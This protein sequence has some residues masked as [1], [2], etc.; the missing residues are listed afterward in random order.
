MNINSFM[1][2]RLMAVA[3]MVNNSESVA[4]IGTDHGYVPVHLVLNN[5]TK[6]AL[7]MDINEGPLARADENI[8]RFQLSEKI[9]TRLSDGLTGLEDN[10]VDTVIIAGMGGI[11]INNIIDKDKERL[12]SVKKYILQPMTAIEETRKYLEKNGF[13]IIDE[14]LAKEGEKIY[15][16]I[17]A[18]PG[19]MKIEK[20]INYYIGEQLIK[21]RD[22]IL[23]EYIKGKIYEYEKA[24]LSMKNA[25]SSEIEEKREYFTYLIS[26]LKILCE[27][28]KKW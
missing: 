13:E 26:E 23:P 20:E 21:N 14:V 16:V 10:E 1:T 22:K 7:A 2:P 27:E 15:T 8:K 17:S 19:R 11:L 5:M 12:S 24:V 25:Q 3:N 18:V 28:C 9:K 4:D 6:C